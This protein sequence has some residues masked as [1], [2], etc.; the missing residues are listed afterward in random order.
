MG[1]GQGE[2][3]YLSITYI[4][5]FATIISVITTCAELTKTVIRFL[6]GCLGTAQGV[7]RECSGT[8]QVSWLSRPRVISA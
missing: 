8:A 2:E 5:P 3:T 7:L 1:K 4:T 6:R